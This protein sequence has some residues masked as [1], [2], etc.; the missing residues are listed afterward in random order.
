MTSL[1]ASN[2]FAEEFPAHPSDYFFYLIFH[3]LQRRNAILDEPLRRIGL[4]MFKWRSML[5][6]RAREDCSMKE[7]AR[8]SGIDR[9]TLTRSVDRLVEDGLV[10]RTSSE[11]DRRQVIL[12]LTARGAVVFDQGLDVHGHYNRRFLKGVPEADQA[13]ICRHFRT[14]LGNMLDDPELTEDITSLNHTAPASGRRL[15]PV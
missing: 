1:E 10:E 6:I 2:D 5:F 8:I 9:T 4:D 12:R 11:R 15:G 14:V 3:L 13:V 7:L